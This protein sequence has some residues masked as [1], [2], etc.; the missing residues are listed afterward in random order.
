MAHQRPSQGTLAARQSLHCCGPPWCPE[1]HWRLNARTPP[2]P[3]TNRYDKRESAP[4][5]PAPASTPALSSHPAGSHHLSTQWIDLTVNTQSSSEL[6]PR[7]ALC[8]MVKAAKPHKRSHTCP[9]TR[10]VR[11]V[12]EKHRDHV[13]PHCAAAFGRTSHLSTHVRTVHEKR[14][15]HACPQCDAAFGQA[16]TLRTHVRT[17]HEQRRDHACPQCDAAFG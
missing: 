13:C 11:E 6:N 4:S 1:K 9:L 15:D 12:R 3:T 10:H 2:S 7:H 5:D 14:K 16:S 17:V 8:P